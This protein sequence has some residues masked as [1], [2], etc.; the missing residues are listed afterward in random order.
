M[1]NSSFNRLRNR[2]A[3]FI[4]SSSNPYMNAFHQIGGTY[5]AYDTDSQTY[6][7]E[8]FGKNPD[9]YAIVKQMGD[10]TASIPW[11]V[12]TIKDETA[13]KR[14]KRFQ[15]ASKYNFTPGQF[16]KHRELITKAFEEK[17]KPFPMERPNVLQTWTEIKALYETFLAT[18]GN[19][20][21]YMKSP[22]DGV[23][24]GQPQELYVLPSHLIQ[25]ILKNRYDFQSDESPIN[26]YMLVEGNMFAEF[27]AQD[28]IHIKLANPFYD[29]NGGHLYGLSPLR[30]GLRNIQSSN[31]AIDN[32][33]KTLTNSGVYGLIHSKG[34]TA[35]TDPQ[36][37][38]VKEKLV[39]MDKSSNRIARISALTAE[40]GFIQIGLKT[41]E[42]KPFDYLKFDQ[43]TICNVLGWEDKLLNN[44]DGAKY[45]NYK[46][47][48]KKALTKTI[49][50]HNKLWEQ[51]FN[52]EFMPRFKGY[53]NCI[54]TFDYSELPEMQPDMKLMTE[55]LNTMLDRG[56][57]SRDAYREAVNF[58]LIG[59]P[60]MEAFTVSMNT[61]NLE[62]ALMNDFDGNID[63][64]DTI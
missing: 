37:K 5:T 48:E 57:I 11:S 61:M 26:K 53:E 21:F 14:L 15:D 23:N 58:P 7:E 41:D 29:A 51:A 17:E 19:V 49:I 52:D 27:P 8:G 2:I 20:Y 47:A 56:V 46:L 60:E 63:E 43:K 33:I 32:N 18:T 31:S 44:D 59:T 12:K 42:L 45:D 30:A 6:M 13:S 10:K 50:P 1:A 40:V 54:L 16:V 28:V 38:A 34:Q 22:E 24:S 9:V 3:S 62:D 64:P 36:A 35:L 55:W 4:S 25:I 39:E